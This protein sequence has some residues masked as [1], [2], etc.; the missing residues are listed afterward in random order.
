MK[1]NQGIRH[2]VKL[3]TLVASM[4]F[5]SNCSTEDEIIA[6]K[7]AS[8]EIASA[9]TN[10]ELEIA[11]FTLSGVYTEVTESIDCA[12]CTYIV[13]AN[14]TVVDG[15]ELAFTPGTVICLDKALKYQSLE[16]NN[17]EGTAESPIIISY[18]GN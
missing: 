2:T 6:P 16:F 10:E 5:L 14:A 9:N 12:T 11:S 15:K 17:M 8:E 13:P 3:F 4:F 7:A 18:C 1:K